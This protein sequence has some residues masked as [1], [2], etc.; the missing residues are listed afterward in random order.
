MP[1]DDG[2]IVRLEGIEKW[3]GQNHV[4]RGIDFSLKEGD[5]QVV[6]GPRRARG[7]RR[8]FAA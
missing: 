6:V 1:N 3:Y 5:V 7:S 2:T 8:C 4:L